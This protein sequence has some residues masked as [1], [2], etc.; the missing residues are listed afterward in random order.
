MLVDLNSGMVKI[1]LKLENKLH[2]L[3]ENI[4]SKY[5]RLN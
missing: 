2:K 4:C 5:N 3:G 1:T